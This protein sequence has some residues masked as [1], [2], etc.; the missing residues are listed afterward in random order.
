ML[1]TNANPVMEIQRNSASVFRRPL[2]VAGLL[3]S[4]GLLLAIR[5][6]A[7]AAAD[8][9]ITAVSS[10]AS[11]V[12]V[13]SKLA[14]GSFQPETYTFGKGGLWAGPMRDPSIDNLQF[15]DVAHTIAG[16]LADRN[17]VPARDPKQVKLLIMVYWGTTAGTS[18]TSSSIAYQ[19]LQASQ[20]IVTL[21]TPP[22]NAPMGT[23]S[24]MAKKGMQTSQTIDESALTVALMANR[25]RDHADAQNAGLLGYATALAAAASYEPTALRG[26]RRDLVDD[27]EENRYFVVLMAY[28]FQLLWKEKKHK[29]LWET[30]FSIRQR[31]ND[32]D[33]QLAAMAADASRY[34]GQDTQGVIRTPLR[35]GKVTLGEPKVLGV[36][37]E[38][39]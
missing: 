5:P 30:R 25:L 21:P 9:E 15:L 10:R 27:L 38:K 17:Y 8:A 33:Q 3:L 7:R 20:S 22:P 19:N 4:S 13:R 39:K 12:Y 34:F 14:D 37:P 16:P 36:E 29:L 6:M 35:E 26:L 11:D 18:D 2:W 31:H 1:P 24:G 32:F 23:P 28:D